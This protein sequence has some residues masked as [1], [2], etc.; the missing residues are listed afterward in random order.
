MAATRSL[1]YFHASVLTIPP[2]QGLTMPQHSVLM[3]VLV[4]ACAW[5]TSAAEFHVAVT[6]NDT[7][8]GTAQQPLRTIQRAADLANPGDTVTVHAGIYRERVDPPRGGESDAK[9]ITYQA[10]PGERVEI[11]GSEV[12]TGWSLVKDRVWKAVIPNA[13]FTGFNPFAD[14][15]SGPWFNPDPT[16]KNKAK[17]SVPMYM[18]L[19]PPRASA[20]S[21]YSRLASCTAMAL[22][23][24]SAGRSSPSCK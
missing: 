12:V 4:F 22:L 2:V 21:W 10:A 20:R 16:A 24:K 18:R 23:T 3:T 13:M 5:T 1:C 15:I 8:Q 9:R 17:V 19:R 11:R 6:G 7:A 14:E